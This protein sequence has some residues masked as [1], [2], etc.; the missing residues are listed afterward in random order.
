MAAGTDDEAQEWSNAFATAS[1]DGMEAY[2]E[3]L[4][5]PMFTR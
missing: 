2:E 1:T 3:A 4:V 5:G